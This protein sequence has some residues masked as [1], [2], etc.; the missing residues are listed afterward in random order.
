[1][2]FIL[3]ISANVHLQNGNC[4]LETCIIVIFIH[5]VTIHSY[6]STNGYS[7]ILYFSPVLQ[8]SIFKMETANYRN[9]HYSHLYP[10][11]AIRAFYTLLQFRKCPSSQLQ[12]IET[13]FCC[14]FK[15]FFHNS[16]ISVRMDIRAC[17]TF[18]FCK[19]PS[20]KSK[21]IKQIL[22]C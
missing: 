6:V 22:L 9:M 16:Y 15:F 14:Y 18:H 11:L 12:T 4:K 21:P 1:M 19:C 3:F 10:F 8:M 2:H 5:F 17:Y 20:S 7:C 13:F